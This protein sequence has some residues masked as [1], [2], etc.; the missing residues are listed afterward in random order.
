MSAR[1]MYSILLALMALATV[2]LVLG[3]GS[4]GK[5]PDAPTESDATPP[6]DSIGEALF[7]DTRFAE[8]FAA[9]MAGVNQPAAEGRSGGGAG[10]D[11]ERSAGGALCGAVDQL[12]VVPFCYG[13]PGR[14]GWRKPHVLGL[15]DAQP[16]PAEPAAAE[17]L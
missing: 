5:A 10:G 2:A 11:D 3:C 12:P 14:D 17:R 8:F 1:R 4:S 16:D 6:A 9:N 7:L 15:Y 13:V